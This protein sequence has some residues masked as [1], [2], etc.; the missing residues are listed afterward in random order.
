MN[1]SNPFCDRT[2]SSRHRSIVVHIIAVFRPKEKAPRSA[3]PPVPKDIYREFNLWKN[4]S[5]LVESGIRGILAV[6]PR[7]F[8]TVSKYEECL[9]AQK[10]E[11]NTASNAATA[12]RPTSQLNNMSHTSDFILW[13]CRRMSSCFRVYQ[14]S[15]GKNNRSTAIINF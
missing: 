9:P 4:L 14:D 5:C 2:L 7:G 15:L 8:C 11:I 10:S 12:I 3:G 1:P 6:V 13:P